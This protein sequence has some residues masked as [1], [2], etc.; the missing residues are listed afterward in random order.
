MKTIDVGTLQITENHVAKVVKALK[1]NRLS[2]GPMTDEFEKR[3]A[4]LHGNKYGVFTNSGT[5]ALQ[6]TIHAMKILYDW[7]DGD[8]IIMPATTFVATYNVILQNKMIPVLVDINEDLNINPQLIEEK[9]TD[10]TRAILPVHLLGKPCDMD[11][12]LTVA[13]NNKLKVIEDSCETMGVPGVGRGDVACFSFY[14]A[15][16][17][18]TG[19]GGMAITNDPELGKLIRSLIFHGRDNKYL[20]INDDDLYSEEVIH[21]RFQFNYPGYSYRGTELEAALGLV[22][23]DLLSRNIS[24]RQE[25]A[26]YLNDQLNMWS[27]SYIDNHAFMMFPLFVGKRNQLMLHLEK[28]G[29]T[30]RTIMPLINQPYINL[31][32]TDYPISEYVLRHGLLVGCHQNLTKKDLDYLIEHIQKGLK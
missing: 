3:F 22:E 5:S 4:Q 26:K 19:V 20:Q 8:E 9:I 12:I 1:S 31:D 6:A 32:T 11:T 17:L 24:K 18:I 29:I 7:Q 14:I 21:A 13:K 15:H 2:Y 16:L 23:L 25:N 28:Q 30:T 27:D 10:K